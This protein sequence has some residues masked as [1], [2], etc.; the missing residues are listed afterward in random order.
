MRKYNTSIFILRLALFIGG[1]FI[2]ANGIVSTIQAGLGINP[3][4]VLHIGLSMQTGLSIGRIIQIVGLTLVGFSCFMKVKPSIGTILNMIFLGLFVDLVIA[5][6][7]IPSPGQAWQKIILF[8][9]GVAIFGFGCSI[10]ISANI[11]TGPRDSLMLALKRITPYR[12][13]A[14]RTI[15]EVSAASSGFLLGGPLGLGTVIFALTVGYF[16]EMGFTLIKMIKE[17]IFFKTFLAEQLR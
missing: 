14:V 10:Y 5:L 1:L 2:V 3:W 17:T 15:M 16:I 12:L 4:D 9:S 6:N 7:Y 11:G 13:G 8:I